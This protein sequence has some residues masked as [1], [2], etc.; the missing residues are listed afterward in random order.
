MGKKIYI[1]SS[2]NVRPYVLVQE[3]FNLNEYLILETHDYCNPPS[4]IAILVIL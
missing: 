4:F 3:S 2:Y 1:D